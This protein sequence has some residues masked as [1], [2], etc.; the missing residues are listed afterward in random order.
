MRALTLGGLVA[1][2]V[3]TLGFGIDVGVA[4]IIIAVVLLAVRPSMQKAA[5]DS[6]PWSAIL[7]VTGIV[8]YVGV[9]DEIGAIDALEEGIAELGGGASFATLVTSYV[10][11]TVSA[12]ASTTGTLGAISPLVVPLAGDPGVSGVGVVS[13][14]SISSSVVDISPMSTTG[15]LLMAN[16]EGPEER[17]FFRALLVW[18]ILMIA[19]VPSVAWAIFVAIGI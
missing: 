5:I 8:T 7:L 16:A 17:T 13:A 19:L 18:A 6:M 14:V 11:A 10:V 2:L 12:F 15:A 4:A 3:L 9:L 1:L